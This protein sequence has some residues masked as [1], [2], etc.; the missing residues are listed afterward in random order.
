MPSVWYA[1]S[2]ESIVHLTRLKLATSEISLKFRRSFKRCDIYSRLDD[3]TLPRDIESSRRAKALTLRWNVFIVSL[4]Y[5]IAYKTIVN[6][7]PLYTFIHLLEKRTIISLK[8]IT[9]NYILIVNL[10]FY[11]VASQSV[12]HASLRDWTR[13]SESPWRDTGTDPSAFHARRRSLRGG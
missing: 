11:L 7:S 8:Y 4:H 10:Q 1:V 9:I 12:S 3:D 5:D 2:R 6:K 13:G